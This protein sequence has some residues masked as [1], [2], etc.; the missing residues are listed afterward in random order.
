MPVAP[1][2][3]ECPPPASPI[4][5]P[6]AEHWAELE[7]LVGTPLPHDYRDLV[8]RYGA[9]SFGVWTGSDESARY[10][11]WLYTLSPGTTRGNLG[12]LKRMV[13]ASQSL[14]Q[15]ADMMP[16]MVPHPAWGQPGGMLFVGQTTTLRYIY[17]RTSGP[18]DQWTCT[19]NDRS[20]RNWF[21]WDGDLTSLLTAFVQQ[22]VPDWILEELPE[23]SIEFVDFETGDQPN[24]SRQRKPH[25]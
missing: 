9:G 22:R 10:F 8:E 4:D 17:W 12:A 5:V 1:L 20:C 16:S 11:D 6:T 13:H 2:L 21:D 14:R 24:S 23:G 18:P 19:V 25:P 3:A 7:R 15:I